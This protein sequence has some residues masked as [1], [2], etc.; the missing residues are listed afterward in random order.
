MKIALD[1]IERFVGS[2]TAKKLPAFP[3][4]LSGRFFTRKSSIVGS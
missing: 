4:T 2:I 1:L 3:V